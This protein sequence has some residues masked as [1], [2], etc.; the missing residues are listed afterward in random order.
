MLLH[1]T[2]RQSPPVTFREALMRGIA[3]DGGLYLP[4]GLPVLARA[5]I[6]AWRGLPLSTLSVRLAE[7]LLSGEAAPD[8][9]ERLVSDA[10]SFPAPTVRVERRSFVLELFHGPTLAFKDFGARFLA[11]LFGHFLAERGGHAT[12]LVATSGDTGSAVAHGFHRVANVRVVLLYPAGKV[13]PFQEA[14][15]SALGGNVIALAVPGTFDDCQRL[16]KAA[17]LDS[18]LEGLRLSSANSINIGRLIPQS[19]YYFASY[20]SMSETPYDS[21]VFSVPSGNLG[22]L[23]AGVMAQRMGLPVR[24]FV[25]ATNVNDVLPEYLR[26]G[27]YR[28]RPAIPTLSNA[29]DVGDPS[30]FPRL[31][32]LHGG[33]LAAMR[34]NLEGIAVSESETRATIRAVYERTGYLLDPHSAVGY[35]AGERYRLASATDAPIIS[36]ATAHPGKFGQAVAEELGFEPGLP[37]A[38]RDWE[39]WPRAIETLPDTRYETFR[40]FL[41]D[42]PHTQVKGA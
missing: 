7:H 17:F 6:E 1:S 24:R 28:A 27:V 41:A 42:C 23:T 18:S 2:R 13:S 8:A 4:V 21:V 39:R 30:N 11:R 14:Q 3:P 33:D 22:N 15:M 36:L 38:F 9:I 31:L 37:E 20:L 32:E 12:I 40:E 35:A 10:F 16:V 26:T 29:M 34:Q 5:Q 25:A 19:F